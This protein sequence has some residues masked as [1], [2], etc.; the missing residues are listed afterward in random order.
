MLGLVFREFNRLGLWQWG[1]GSWALRPLEREI[2]NRAI[3]LMPEDQRDKAQ[4]QLGLRL[5]V[6]RSNRMIN[7][8]RAYRPDPALR[9]SA[10]WHGTLIKVLMTVNGAKQMAN[11]T[12]YEGYLFTVEFRKPATF[13]KGKTIELGEA[14]LGNPGQ[15]YTRLID[16]AEHG[17]PENE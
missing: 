7:V 8:I 10:E 2:I 6:E 3:T 4:A 17:R 1:E 16:R 14:K 15:S 9:L 11:V 13:Y 5:F 12:T